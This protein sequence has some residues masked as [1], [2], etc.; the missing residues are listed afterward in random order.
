MKAKN[1]KVVPKTM[2]GRKLV[3][4]GTYRTEPQKTHEG[5]KRALEE[6]RSIY[7]ESYGWKEFDVRID[8][9]KGEFVAVR[10]HALYK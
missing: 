7:S 10:H 2:R 9:V 8:K 3:F 4:E 6:V 5:A 1:N